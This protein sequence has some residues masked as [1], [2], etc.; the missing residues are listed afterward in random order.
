M[1]LDSPLVL[2]FHSVN[3]TKWDISSY[4]NISNMSNY[5]EFSTILR[6]IEHKIF[7]NS[8]LFI[9]NKGIEPTWEDPKNKVGGTWSFKIDD[10]R[11]LDVWWNINN[12]FIN[13]TLFKE[14]TI[15]NGLSVAPKKGYY[16]LK[17]WSGEKADKCSFS[18]E[19]ENIGSEF[20][21][22]SSQYK[23]N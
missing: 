18:D 3:N 8:M 19:L 22:G 9:M 5:I 4:K 7:P 17:I 1:E 10:N 21:K 16:I 15:V 12:L 23:S 6:S 11:I 13:N 2:W 14:D 20:N